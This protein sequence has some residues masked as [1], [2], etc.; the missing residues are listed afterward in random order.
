M[1]VYNYF[2]TQWADRDAPVDDAPPQVARAIE[3]WL[4]RQAVGAGV[5]IRIGEIADPALT[6]LALHAE[7]PMPGAELVHVVAVPDQRLEGDPTRPLTELFTALYGG[8]PELAVPKLQRELARLPQTTG[9]SRILRHF[10]LPSHVEALR[11]SAGLGPARSVTEPARA[12]RSVGSRVASRRVLVAVGFGSL[13]LGLGVAAIPQIQAFLA[14]ERP[15]TRESAL[16]ERI[17]ALEGRI[18][19]LSR[20][21]RD[22]AADRRLA[23]ARIERRYEAPPSPVHEQPLPPLEVVGEPLAPA[24]AVEPAPALAPAVEPAPTSEPPPAQSPPL[25]LPGVAAAPPDGVPDEPPE[26]AKAGFRV[27]A[28]TARVRAGPSSDAATRGLLAN[29]AQVVARSGDGEW[30]EIEPPPDFVA[31]TWVHHSVLVASGPVAP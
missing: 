24:V 6:L 17:G 11:W 13:C 5:G 4:G 14:S 28:R 12:T 15:R 29:G 20:E 18:E 26:A 30:I 1:E 27:A 8:R 25:T 21:L 3:G 22:E 23:L 7:G 16:L 31:P 10:A 9:A 2:R 19:S